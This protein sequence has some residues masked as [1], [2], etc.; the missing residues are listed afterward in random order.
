M[1]VENSV[2]IKLKKED[3]VKVPSYIG[4]F[5][6][7]STYSVEVLYYKQISKTAV[8]TEICVLISLDEL[9]QTITDIE[10]WGKTTK[11]KS[12]QLQ[13]DSHDQDKTY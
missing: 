5:T 11:S 12:Q 6:F 13:V 7:F 2:I 4:E 1:H 10:N 8:Y 9:N 3:K